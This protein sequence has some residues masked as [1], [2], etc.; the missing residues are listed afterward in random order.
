MTSTPT[1]NS[2]HAYKVP[3]LLCQWQH[4]M[5]PCDTMYKYL[6]FMASNGAVPY[7][8][9][10]VNHDETHIKN[11]YHHLYSQKETNGSISFEPK[12]SCSQS[13][14]SGLYYGY[15]AQLLR[16]YKSNG[17]DHLMNQRCP[18]LSQGGKYQCPWV[19][20]EIIQSFSVFQEKGGLSA[21]SIRKGMGAFNLA[22]SMQNQMIRAVFPKLPH[23]E[24]AAVT[25]E[26]AIYA[27]KRARQKK[28]GVYNTAPL[29][30]N[31]KKRIEQEDVQKGCVEDPVSDAVLTKVNYNFL[32]LGTFPNEYMRAI[33]RVLFSWSFFALMRGDDLRNEVTT[34]AHFGVFDSI[35]DFGPTPANIFYIMKDWS[36][37]SQGKVQL[38]AVLRHSNVLLCPVNAI[39]QLLLSTIGRNGLRQSW[40]NQLLDP[41]FNWPKEGSWIITDNR[42]D[43]MKYSKKRQSMKRKDSEMDCTFTH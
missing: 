4:G 12:S 14:S 6:W 40:F 1:P 43:I 18:G 31:S 27:R 9:S 39:G 3:P 5:G 33:F 36:K 10:L 26:D 20:R 32:R 19:F 24:Q 30:G 34:W 17:Y 11:T 13:N 35:K 22:I 29:V 21:A 25:V 2:S 23:L 42:G 15:Y 28:R 8:A 7:D 38:C 37:N 16:F 41:T